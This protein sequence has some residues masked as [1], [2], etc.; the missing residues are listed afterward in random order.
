MGRVSD[1][2]KSLVD[3]DTGGHEVEAAARDAAARDRAD[4]TITETDVL[5]RIAELADRIKGERELQKR[6]KSSIEEGAADIARLMRSAPTNVYEGRDGERVLKYK[7]RLVTVSDTE[8]WEW[9]KEG[10]AS[11]YETSGES[12][13]EYVEKTYTVKKA[14]FE[15]LSPDQKAELSPFLTIEGGPAKVSVEHTPDGVE[16]LE[17][18]KTPF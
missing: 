11:K 7:G 1:D 6:L 10:L 14:K 2:W 16:P 17:D 12:L 18:K 4:I 13:P 3:E 8:R 9:D 5:E 15:K